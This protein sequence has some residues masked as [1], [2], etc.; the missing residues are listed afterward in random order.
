LATTWSLIGGISDPDDETLEDTAVRELKEETHVVVDPSK[1]TYIC[2]K[3]VR[4]WRYAD[5]P[6]DI[7]TVLFAA[8][9]YEGRPIETDE[10]VEL[11]W[12]K[13]AVAASMARGTHAY[14]LE[15]L[16]KKVL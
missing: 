2:S 5:G 7:K 14:L 12:V 9:E 1:L 13:V 3:K 11:G 6:D 4:D 16:A 8:W 15:Q 10:M